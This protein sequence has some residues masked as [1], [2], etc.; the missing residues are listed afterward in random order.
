MGEHARRITGISTTTSKGIRLYSSKH[1][2]IRC[3]RINLTKT[4]AHPK[5]HKRSYCRRRRL[6]LLLRLLNPITSEHDPESA[7][8]EEAGTVNL[9]TVSV[10]INPRF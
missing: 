3:A 1:S 7:A 5:A 6:L 8:R 9:F 10:F 4:V 2:S